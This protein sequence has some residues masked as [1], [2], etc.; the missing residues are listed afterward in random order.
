MY[1]PPTEQQPEDIIDINKV[2]PEK[3]FEVFEEAICKKKIELCHTLLDNFE[4]IYPD[5]L[6]QIKIIS[7]YTDTYTVSKNVNAPNLLEITIQH[8]HNDQT[9]IRKICS[10]FLKQTDGISQ[11]IISRYVDWEN[12]APALFSAVSKDNVMAVEVLLNPEVTFDKSDAAK[13]STRFDGKTALHN[14]SLNSDKSLKILQLLLDGQADI[15]QKDI[16]GLTPYQHLINN[17]AKLFEIKD[18]DDKDIFDYVN[19]AA[20]MCPSQKARLLNKL[21]EDYA[22]YCVNLKITN[23]KKRLISEI[24]GTNE[25]NSAKKQKLE[26]PSESHSTNNRRYTPAILPSSS[27]SFNSGVPYQQMYAPQPEPQPQL[28]PPPQSSE[29][30]NYSFTPTGY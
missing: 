10:F 12:E 13:F 14:L 4:R 24:S 11:G 8:I 28:Q 19:G 27:S 15:F 22:I 20:K 1:T 7:T 26:K 23:E 21:K 29:N 2:K 17:P 5:K 3:F 18:T 6:T 25:E 16:Q 30:N 9:V